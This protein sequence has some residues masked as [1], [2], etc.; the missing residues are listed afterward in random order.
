MDLR[1][2]EA[3]LA[4]E[5]GAPARTYLDTKGILSGGIGHNLIDEPEPGYDRIGVQVSPE[6]RSQWFRKDIE[7][8][9]NDLNHHAPW[10]HGLDDV[11]QNALL[12]LCFN[13]GWGGLST[14]K[15]TLA[16]FAAKD[17]AQAANGFR[18]SQYANDVGPARSGRVCRMIETGQWPADV[19]E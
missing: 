7:D 10:W 6:T 8:A 16:A 13:M 18:H 14:F 2:L 3:Q 1:K 4:L 19:P 9:I 15:N 5:E 12:N 11:R 17:Y